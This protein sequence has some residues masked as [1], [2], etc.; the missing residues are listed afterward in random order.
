M[1]F[2]IFSSTSFLLQN[3]QLIEFNKKDLISAQTLPIIDN[4]TVITL[5]FASSWVI[6]YQNP[7][8]RYIGFTFPPHIFNSYRSQLGENSFPY[9]WA[10]FNF[11]AYLE[12]ELSKVLTQ[13]NSRIY[14]IY[15]K[16]GPDGL[17]A[18]QDAIAYYSH[19]RRILQNCTK[20]KSPSLHGQL[21]TYFC[22]INLKN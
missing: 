5:N 20:I 4:S 3:P 8:A 1:A 22:E 7:N 18:W 12:N 15:D 6:P 19:G 17:N 16:N 11:S 14:G 21:N 9:F 2:A 13:P 10:Q